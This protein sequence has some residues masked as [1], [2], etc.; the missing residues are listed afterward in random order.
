MLHLACI[1]GQSDVVQ[2]LQR[3]PQL[4]RNLCND[5]GCTPLSLAARFDHVRCASLVTNRALACRCNLMA[6]DNDGKTPLALA[7]KYESWEVFDL[8]LSRFGAE[9]TIDRHNVIA[10]ERNDVARIKQALQLRKWNITTMNCGLLVA[11]NLERRAA[12]NTLLTHPYYR[13]TS[14]SICSTDQ[15]QALLAATLLQVAESKQWSV[16]E[17]LACAIQTSRQDFTSSTRAAL[18]EVM[19]KTVQ[20]NQYELSRYLFDVLGVNPSA[21]VHSRDTTPLQEAHARGL[22]DL[23]ATF[24]K[25]RPPD[26]R[27]AQNEDI[28][29]TLDIYRER[30]MDVF[31]AARRGCYKAETTGSRGVRDLLFQDREVSTSLPGTV[32]GPAGVSLLHIATSVSNTNEAPLWDVGDVHNLVYAHGAYIN[33]VD[34]TGNTPLHYLAEKASCSS[35]KESWDEFSPYEQWASLARW[36]LRHGADPTLANYRGQLPEDLSAARENYRLA[37]LLRDARMS[38]RCNGSTGTADEDH[39]SLLAAASL[40]KLEAIRELLERGASMDP[41]CGYSSP[42]HLAITRGQRDAA[43]LLLSAGASLTSCSSDGLTVLQA[44]HRTPDLPALFPAFIRQEYVV[45]LNDEFSRV[46]GNSEECRELRRGLQQ[47][48]T[49]IEERGCEA[50]WPREISWGTSWSLLVEAARLGLPLTC[51]FLV[52]AGARMCRLPRDLSHPLAVAAENRQMNMIKVL[53]RDLHMLPYGIARLPEN[54]LTAGLVT[55]L[56]QEEIARLEEL[57]VQN[58]NIPDEDAAEAL[59][60]YEQMERSPN[61]LVSAS[62]LRLAGKCGLVHLL[63]FARQRTRVELEDVVDAA[64]GSK[65][66]HIAARNGRTT[67]VEYLAAVNSV[68]TD[69]TLHKT[70]GFT[71][72]HLAALMGHTACFEYLRCFPGGDAQSVVGMTPLD[73]LRGFQNNVEVLRLNVVSKR[74]ENIIFNENR[75]DVVSK[76]LLEVKARHMGIFS[77]AQLREAS[78]QYKVNFNTRENLRINRTITREMTRLCQRIGELDP[79]YEGNLVQVGSVAE[80]IRMFTADEMD[81]NLELCNFHCLRG[82]R[83]TARSTQRDDIND[84][85]E[86]T[87]ESDEEPEMFRNQNFI[88]FFKRA[89]ER[90]LENFQF[91]SPYL[92]VIY[93]GLETTK[94]G[95]ALYMAWCEPGPRTLLLSVDLVP[96]VRAPWP[97]VNGLHQLPYNI[98]EE[99]HDMPV[100]LT[101]CGQNSWRYSLSVTEAR[102]ISDLCEDNKRVVIMACKLICSMLKYD[103]WYPEKYKRHYQ[104]WNRVYLKLDSPVS[105]IIKTLFTKEISRAMDWKA[106][107]FIERIMSIFDN[108]ISADTSEIARVK[109]FLLPEYESNRFGY[110]APAIKSFLEDLRSGRLRAAH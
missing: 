96:A 75:A 74:E 102:I 56:R 24:H 53:C 109:S 105:Y 97:E 44:A 16:V 6:R 5:Q 45:L 22:T 34:S 46:T 83:V 79:R 59:G 54:R 92:S 93:P 91:Q 77:P 82:G 66:L 57:A 58:S 89:T 20:A 9:R 94:V 73:L 40:G 29:R 12:L 30:I 35:S 65:L 99:V 107:H 64:S 37:A 2:E 95:L 25:N 18:D 101:S 10:I 13:E 4:H 86:V 41:R 32:R 103:W 47:L 71:A 8:L 76:T 70:G 60:C 106:E 1:R 15:D 11:A 88:L 52:A 31:D 51:Q 38:R 62:F 27:F 81:F 14:R 108:M 49:A 78:L 23:I 3:H 19:W 26:S 28:R 42:L 55:Y 80:D 17:D 110:G 84:L 36:L 72:A 90:A 85:L 87:L 48:Q 50:S 43:M 67:M 21:Q 68:R 39:Q 61:S 100:S 69:T 33:A 104:V 7:I 63:H 98:R